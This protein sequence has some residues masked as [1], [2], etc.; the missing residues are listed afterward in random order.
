MSALSAYEW[1]NYFSFIHIYIFSAHRRC[2]YFAAECL[3]LLL[4]INGKYDFVFSLFKERKKRL[5]K[6]IEDKWRALLSARVEFDGSIGTYVLKTGP[7]DYR[8]GDFCNNAYY[9]T[10]EQLHLINFQ[11]VKLRS[12]PK[13]NVNHYFLS[14]LLTFGKSP[15]NFWSYYNCLPFV[16]RYYYVGTREL[17]SVFQYLMVWSNGASWLLHYFFLLFDELLFHAF[18][19][20]TR[21]STLNYMFH[22][23]V[24]VAQPVDLFCLCKTIRWHLTLTS[25]S[26]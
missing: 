21:F 16:I 24:V 6:S 8:S 12:H 26:N 10:I 7:I 23:I 2:F 22:S 19:A 18:G 3:L 13:K 14:F 4:F 20:H 25:L 15:A 1:P 11:W 5:F 9:F 17:R